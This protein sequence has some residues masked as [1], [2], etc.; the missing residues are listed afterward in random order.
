MTSTIGTPEDLVNDA[1]PTT[2]PTEPAIS[3]GA[4]VTLGSLAVSGL[5]AIGV[6]VTS[7][8]K[9]WLITAVAIL[10][11]MLVGVLVRFKVFAPATVAGMVDRLNNQLADAKAAAASAQA[12]QNAQQIAQVAALQ[13][14]SVSME[15]TKA[16]TSPQG[17]DP[18]A[19]GPM[20]PP[21]SSY[22]PQGQQGAQGWPPASSYPPPPEGYKPVQIDGGPGLFDSP[23]RHYRT[24]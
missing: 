21:Q 13:A 11:P 6:P 7:D 16:L 1:M 17:A 2:A 18:T 12:A 22:A 4:W 9:V 3:T 14:V 20:T 24:D 5:V 19:A 10:G 8:Q 15:K 23:A